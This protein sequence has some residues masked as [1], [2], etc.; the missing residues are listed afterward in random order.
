MSEPEYPYQQQ[1]ERTL[2]VLKRAGFTIEE[3]KRALV[4]AKLRIEA[5]SLLGVAGFWS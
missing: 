4:E 1:D 3:A 2:D 5:A